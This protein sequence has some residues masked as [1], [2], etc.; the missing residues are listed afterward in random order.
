V[1]VS[2]TVTLVQTVGTFTK[3]SA[4]STVEIDAEVGVLIGAL[5]STNGV[6]IYLAVDGHTAQAQ[7]AYSWESSTF[8]VPATWGISHHLKG[9]F[10]GLAAGTHTVQIYAG[11]F[12]GTA[13]VTVNYENFYNPVWVREN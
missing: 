8:S 6:G 5:V 13:N 10:L 9:V 1:G 4:G 3:L 12:A 11:T 7:T 2:S